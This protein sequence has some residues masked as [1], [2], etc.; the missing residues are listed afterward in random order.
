MD[1]YAVDPIERNDQ[2]F[3]CVL[4]YAGGRLGRLRLVPTVVREFQ[5]RLAAGVERREIEQKMQRLC[6]A[7]GTE[8]HPTPDGLGWRPGD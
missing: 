7:L 1:D 2:S 6:A 3:L 8:V 4:E 5:A